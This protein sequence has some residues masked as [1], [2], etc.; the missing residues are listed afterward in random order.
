M[1]KKLLILFALLAACAGTMFGDPV[2]IG[3]LYYNLDDEN[4]TAEV[5][6]ETRWSGNNYA[7]LTALS[8]PSAV[9][10]N[11]VS[12]SVTR[13]G[14][15]AFASCT[16]LTAVTIPD[17]ITTIGSWAFSNCTSLASIDIPNSVSSINS[18]AFQSCEALTSIVIPESISEISYCMFAY[19]TN[20]SSVILPKSLTKIGNSAFNMCQALTSMEIPMGVSDIDAYA[21]D[22]CSG[23][24]SVTLPASLT[25]IGN[26]AFRDCSSL[27]GITIPDGVQTIGENAFYD[28]RALTS[29]DIP[30]S[31]TSIGCGAF[32]ACEKLSAINVDTNNASYCSEDGVLFK[33]DKTSLIQCP[34]GKKGT[35]VIPEG[36]SAI[37][38]Y[39]FWGCT[40][41]SSI[42]VPESVASIGAMAFANC[43]F[44]NVY[45]NNLTAWLGIDFYAREAN[46]L[47]CAEHWYLNE[48]ESSH[49][50]IPDGITTIKQ[51][52]FSGF[53]G[54]RAITIPISLTHIS[55][56]AFQ[57]CDSL[58]NVYI[59][60]IDA[61]CK[62][63]FDS[64]D[65]NPLRYAHNLYI[66]NQKTT[67]L[68]IPGTV[69]M[70]GNYTFQEFKGIT[71]LTLSEGVRTVGESSFSR[72]INLSSITLPQ[73]LSSIGAQAFYD[74]T[75]VTTLTV[76]DNVTEIEYEAFYNIF[77]VAYNGN[78]TGSPWGAKN[79]N[80]VIDGYLL[81]NADKTAILD[82]REEA[83]G[84]ISI[85]A[86]VTSIGDEAFD[87]C[88][89]ITAFRADEQS[90]TYSSL[91]G[92]LYNKNL[93]KLIF[94]P[95][96]KTDKEFYM[97]DFV[98][99]IGRKA[100]YSP[101]HLE[102]VVLSHNLTAVGE[103]MTFYSCP[104]LKTVIIPNG[105]TS[106]GV[107]A[108][109]VCP[110]LNDLVLPSS[111]TSIGMYGLCYYGFKQT[112][113]L[114]CEA[115]NPPTCNDYAFAGAYPDS[116]TIY[117]PKGSVEAYKNAKVWKDFT[118][119]PIV[120]PGVQ[121]D[122]NVLVEAD[123]ASVTITWPKMDEAAAYILALLEAN[124]DTVGVYNFNKEGEL[125]RVIYRAP[126][127]DKN[128]AQKHLQ[129]EGFT[130]TILGLNSGTTYNYSLT[131][132]DDLGAPLKVESG[133]FTTNAPQAIE[134]LQ[135]L[136]APRK[137]L[138]NGQILILRG[139]KTYTITGQEVK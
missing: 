109:Y 134:D 33:K 49:V 112:S 60:D 22:R 62:I 96:G 69:E 110:E 32:T 125:E 52:A 91:D 126:S 98:T 23:L 38:A 43:K 116:L 107:G 118:I 75:G 17:G 21:F 27:A 11:D 25:S 30:Q 16:T 39:A 117:V 102:K 51:Y 104:A 72:C 105:I 127:R 95:S 77:N 111:I 132:E 120:A 24:V 130:F 80:G 36:V 74:C 59:T 45:I 78:A 34:A 48:Q 137:I 133:S 124:D 113:T 56:Y 37:W 53:N 87:D 55:Y 122:E 67:E 44:E 29:V 8:I 129:T 114:V 135:L 26:Y 76:P 81:F 9:E 68:I 82:C 14:E 2:K 123:V 12:Y 73:S 41:I 86:T 1:R 10:Y 19:C 66:N 121:T 50:I 138:N 64:S 54:L 15:D 99:S 92:V 18:Y 115:V 57:W 84:V 63:E 131:A 40:G 4:Q 6:Y 35:F 70:V 119:L 100:F 71:S 7:A 28:C 88:L 139:D 79:I 90:A 85:P 65:S 61:W 89:G 136:E 83:E 103:Y 42:T 93:T 97:P 20:L 128:V 46:P 106:L 13:I 101:K 47:H 31:V 58:Q 3:D 5:T 108:F 94:Y